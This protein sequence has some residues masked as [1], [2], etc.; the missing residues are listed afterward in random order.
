[1][2]PRTDPTIPVLIY[3]MFL[4]SYF[5]ALI[6]AVIGVIIAHASESGAAEPARS[7]YRYQIRVFWTGFFIL[8]SPILLIPL[9]FTMIP[10]MVIPGLNVGAILTF[11]MSV[12]WLVVFPLAWFI[13]TLVM[14]IRGLIRAVNGQNA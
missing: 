4:M 7:H 12:G 3:A 10:A 11:L 8:I 13:Y 6:P 5:M 9:W 1:M 14:T 2:S